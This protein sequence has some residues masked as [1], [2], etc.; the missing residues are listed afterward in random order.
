MQASSTRTLRTPWQSPDGDKCTA[1]RVLLIAEPLFGPRQ[2]SRPSRFVR[3]AEKGCAGHAMTVLRLRLP[4]FS[5]P[6]YAAFGTRSSTRGALRRT[7]ASVCR[8]AVDQMSCTERWPRNALGATTSRQNCHCRI[9]G[10]VLRPD[11]P[12]EGKDADRARVRARRATISPQQAAPPLDREG[13]AIP[14]TEPWAGAASWMLMPDVTGPITIQHV[15]HHLSHSVGRQCVS[16]LRNVPSRSPEP[17]QQLASLFITIVRT[18]PQALEWLTDTSRNLFPG[19]AA[20]DL[21]ARSDIP[22]PIAVISRATARP[23][24]L[25]VSTPNALGF[26]K[27]PEPSKMWLRHYSECPPEMTGARRATRCRGKRSAAS[28]RPTALAPELAHT[29][30]RGFRVLRRLRNVR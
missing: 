20:R 7:P 4:C 12:G 18:T 24:A 13:S 6:H 9:P 27:L 2:L 3:V 30:P 21:V 11:L 23:A 26:A 22:R 1:L 19:P 28:R 16:V 29:T 8:M 15:D 5:A 17:R 25:F 14:S 10:S